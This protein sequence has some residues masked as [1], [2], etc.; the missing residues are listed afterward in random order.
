MYKFNP[1]HSLKFTYNRRINR[2]D[3]YNLNPYAR[4]NNDLSVSAGNPYLEPEH[5]DKLQLTY[6]MNIKKIN[7]SPYLYHEFYS[8]KIANRTT[9]R[10]SPVTGK[11]T[12][13]NA[14]ENLLTGYEQGFGLNATIFSFNING[15]IYR[16]HFNAFTDSLSHIGAR[17]Y[18][19]FRLTSYVYAP[20]FKEKFHVFAFINYNGINRSGQTTTYS[21]LFYGLGMQQN[22]KDHT[23]GIFYLLPFSKTIQFS[24]VI[25]ETPEIYSENRQLFDAS[26]FIQLT[27]SYK[28]NKGRAIKKSA[29]KADVESDTKRGGLGQ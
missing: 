3:I 26:W 6:S 20:L 11:Q 4:L 29:R 12:V 28:F 23:W 18:F 14:P 15:S 27:Y 9:L 13:Y 7:F 21:P 10:F 19:S 22:I 1:K 8:N 24:K 2:P 5:K 17:D 25:T 16:G